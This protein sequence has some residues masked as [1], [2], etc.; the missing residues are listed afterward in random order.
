M[1]NWRQEMANE[2]DRFTQRLSDFINWEI[3]Q[4][5]QRLTLLKGTSQTNR[6]IGTQA[7]EAS[8]AMVERV[9]K[10]EGQ[11]MTVRSTLK[12]EAYRAV[13]YK[14]QELKT[15]ILSEVNQRLTALETC[16]MHQMNEDRQTM[17]N[18]LKE[19]NDLVAAVR[20][21]QQKTWGAI[22]RI[23]K[24]L[25]ELIQKD[26]SAEEEDEADEDLAPGTTNWDT[27]ESAL[28]ATSSMG[29]PWP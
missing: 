29:T 18:R 24:D 26:A 8:Q 21:G 22:E 5:G 10:V 16:L 15:E 7:R 1:A 17:A 6:D 27:V 19:I 13:G 12:T 3:Y 28:A 2:F 14:S 4:F 23:S 25:Q 11:I 9:D 20:E